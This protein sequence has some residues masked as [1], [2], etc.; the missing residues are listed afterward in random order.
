MTDIQKETLKELKKIDRLLCDS[1][2][3]YDESAELV[4]DENQALANKF[5]HM[6][7]NRKVLRTKLLAEI[8]KLDTDYDIDDDGTIKGSIHQAFME[9]K[10]L[11]SDDVE[12]AEK[13]IKRG[14][15][16]LIEQ[17][18]EA[19]KEDITIEAKNV[20]AEILKELQESKYVSITSSKAA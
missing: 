6:E 11:F 12:V 2:E 5:N 3:G 19:H 13:E 15:D 17:I 1:I 14:E 8:V 7:N 20:L 18:K 16:Y 4:E 10:A 9:F